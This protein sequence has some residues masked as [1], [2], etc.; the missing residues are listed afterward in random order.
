MEFNDKNLKIPII[1]KIKEE[2]ESFLDIFSYKTQGRFKENLKIVNLTFDSSYSN[3]VSG[4]KALSD[5]KP[6]LYNSDGKVGAIN[7][8]TTDKVAPNVRIHEWWHAL[9]FSRKSPLIKDGYYLSHG[10]TRFNK[11][12]LKKSKGTGFEEGM[13]EVTSILAYFKKMAKER[14][15]PSILKA[16]D[17]FMET[18]YV[19]VALLGE[20]QQGYFKCYSDVARLFI[21]ASRNDFMQTHNFAEVLASAEGIDGY[22][23]SPVNKPYST[24]IHSAVHSDPEF[25]E[26]YDW[27]LKATK[28][29]LSYDK[30]GEIMDGWYTTLMSN[31]GCLNDEQKKQM[32][33]IINSISL[34]NLAKLTRNYLNGDISKERKKALIVK[35]EKIANI[36]REEYKVQQRSIQQKATNYVPPRTSFRRK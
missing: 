30:I 2:Y 9:V 19:N 31:R 14:K 24:Y 13:A 5:V 10:L 21:M 32:Q 16:A 27:Y 26:E 20:F 29:M 11:N 17:I 4:G 33:D 18:G 22:I 15:N 8:T 12:N 34:Y 6:S 23:A 28:E 7:L 35:F 36:L 3:M 25:Q 1:K